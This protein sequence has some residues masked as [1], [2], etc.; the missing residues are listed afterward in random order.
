[1]SYVPAAASADGR[2]SSRSP[3]GSPQPSPLASPGAGGRQRGHA[4]PAAS[5]QKRDFEAK[6]RGF[7]KKLDVKGYGQGPGKF[8]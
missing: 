1:M 3:R 5:G 7:Y 2:P 4:P 8:K 6:L